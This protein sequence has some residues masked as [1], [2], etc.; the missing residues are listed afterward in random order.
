MPKGYN[1]L[2]DVV[3]KTIDGLDLNSMWGEFQEVLSLHNDKRST[4]VNLL[5]YNVTNVI[6]SVPVTASGDFEEASE[7]GVPQS[8]RTKVSA[9][10][11]AYD[12]KWYDTA[13]RFTWQFL[14]DASSQQVEAIHQQV[15]EADNRLVFNKIM[16]TLFNNENRTADINGQN[17]NVYAFYNGDGTVPPQNGP[18]VF[19]G[20]YTHYL[21]SGG[22]VIDSGDLEEIESRFKRLGYGPSTGTTAV[23]LVNTEEA[24]AIRRFRFNEENAN[25]A[26]ALHD[27]IPSA[28]QPTLFLQNQQGLLGS[29]PPSTYNGLPVIGSYGNLLIIEEDYIPAGYAVAFVTGGEQSLSNPIGFRQHSNSALHGLRLLPG[30]DSTYPLTN[31]NYIRGFGTGVRQRGAGLVMQFKASGAYEIPEAYSNV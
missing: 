23:I 10:Q 17:Y 15:L 24:N 31:S 4:I 21:V 8:N 6:E 30:E 14:A 27:F 3:H 1:T 13:K 5:T 16:R 25:G 12:F 11:M 18:N 7:F 2:G 19:D 9:F 20:D 22:S 26:I 28:T 29:Q